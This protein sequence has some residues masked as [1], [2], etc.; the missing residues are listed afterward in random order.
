MKHGIVDIFAFQ[1]ALLIE[2]VFGLALLTMIWIAFRRW[3]HHKDQMA[4]LNADHGA[5][6][7]AQYDSRI[8]Q[9]EERL[10]AI[11]S[12]AAGGRAEKTGAIEDAPSD[13]LSP[14]P[15]LG[16]DKIRPA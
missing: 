12:S 2:A 16:R 14:S 15:E 9:L 13:M 6:R 11:E 4:R 7:D 8:G 5:E 10:K 3:L 1:E